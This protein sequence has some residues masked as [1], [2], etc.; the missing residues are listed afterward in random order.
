[1]FEIKKDPILGNVVA[2]IDPEVLLGLQDR[3]VLKAFAGETVDPDIAD[4]INDGFS[5]LEAFLQVV[6]GEEGVK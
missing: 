1:M 2:D 6:D 3:V 4:W 5:Q